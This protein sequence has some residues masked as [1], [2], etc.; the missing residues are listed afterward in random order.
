M[1]EAAAAP[2]RRRIVP[3][4]VGVVLAALLGGGGFFGVRSGLIP[5]PGKGG[6]EIAAR[7]TPIAFVPVPTIMV[8]MGT[9]Q[10]TRHLRF[11]AELEV[12]RV[13]ASEVAQLM[14]R[15]LDVLNGYLRAVEMADVE[16][17]AGI[18]RLRAQM[19]RRVQIVT[20]PGRVSDLLVTEFVLN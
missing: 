19:L 15:I 3:L 11:T 12:P 13:H 8:S 17:R 18:F 1:S 6:A 2:P 14:P 7:P 4:I 16:D 10:R 20:G 9:G 5:I